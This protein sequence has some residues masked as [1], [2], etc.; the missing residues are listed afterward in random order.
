MF[1]SNL[2]ASRASRQTSACD[3]TEAA[4]KNDEDQ[5]EIWRRRLHSA[6]L[7]IY[8]AVLTLDMRLVVAATNISA[9]LDNVMF[10]LLEFQVYSAAWTAARSA[11]KPKDQW[12]V[13][14]S[15]ARKAFLN[16]IIQQQAITCN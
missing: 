9:K 1:V 4:K 10:L 8:F 14:A 11:G 15:A 7:L 3:A 5:D 2:H 6:P 16:S 12:K 13:L